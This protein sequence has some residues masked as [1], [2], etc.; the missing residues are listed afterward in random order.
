MAAALNRLALSLKQL[1]QVPARVSRPFAAYVTRELQRAARAQQDPYGKGHAPLRPA[2]VRKKGHDTI[3][4][5]TNTLIPSLKGVPLGGA[6]VG[7]SVDPAYA[8][9]HITGTPHMVPRA[10]MPVSGMP[11]AWRAELKRLV[12]EET[13]KVMG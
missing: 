6:G 7:L 5:E 9:Y 1:K 8:H 4:E 13:K 11:A 12:S 10:F 2:T 3:L